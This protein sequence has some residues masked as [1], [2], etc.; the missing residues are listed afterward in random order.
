MAERGDFIV[1]PRARSWPTRSSPPTW[2][3]T[4]RELLRRVQASQFVYEH[5]DQVCSS[6]QLDPWRGNHRAQPRPR[7]PAVIDTE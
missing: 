1:S 2:A 7:R 6:R 4:P 5:G 3:A